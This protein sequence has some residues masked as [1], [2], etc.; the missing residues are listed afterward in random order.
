M[1]KRICDICGNEGAIEIY[2]LDGGRMRDSG[3]GKARVTGKIFDI[4]G[5]CLMTAYDEACA[6]TPDLDDAND[7]AF[8]RA[9]MA[10]LGRTWKDGRI[11]LSGRAARRTRSSQR[12][13]ILDVLHEAREPL[14]GPD[15]A[16]RT[17]MDA[18][19]VKRM[20]AR[21]ARSGDIERVAYGRY[22]APQEP[23][24]TAGAAAEAGG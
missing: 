22:S 14:T 7:D 21:M 19:N 23:E 13:A 12:R 20:L 17:G 15:I 4:C 10:R 2:V 1:I 8:N 18:A 3:S 11:E 9:L 24:E 5:Q 6:E 16:E